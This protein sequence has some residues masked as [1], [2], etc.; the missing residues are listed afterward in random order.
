MIAKY[1]WVF[2]EKFSVN[3]IKLVTIIVL[4]RLITP[5]EFGVFAIAMYIITTCMV[6]VD[7]GMAGSLIKERNINN[8]DYSTVNYYNIFLSLFLIFLIYILSDVVS[9]YYQ[10]QDLALMLKFMSIFL[11]IR[12]FTIVH[13]VYLSKKMEFR[14]QTYV[15][16]FSAIVGGLGAVILAW[17]NYGVWSLIAQQMI[18]LLSIYFI[19]R[20]MNSKFSYGYSFSIKTL[21]KHFNF[22]IKLTFSTILESLNNNIIINYIGKIGGINLV[23]QYSQMTKVN[24]IYLGVISSAVDKAALPIFVRNLNN[25][26]NLL[27]L[28]KKT[29]GFLG[30]FVYLGISILIIN[31][32][33]VVNILLGNNWVE[34]SWILQILCLL[35]YMQIVDTIVRSYLKAKD[36]PNI[37]LFNS[38][39]KFLVFF[40]GM[41]LSYLFTNDVKFFVLMLVVWSL[42][43]TVISLIN[44]WFNVERR[45]FELVYSVFKPLLV[46][47][48]TILFFKNFYFYFESE[49]LLNDFFYFLLNCMVVST[50]YFLL[51]FVFRVK[52]FF[53]IL[54]IIKRRLL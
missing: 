22:G 24:D 49:S 42:M 27:E 51:L 9:K 43:Y 45:I 36:L 16:A 23:G 33:L 10:N 52:E 26:N 14:K 29:L 53:T 34:Y 35:G 40:V 3:L 2:A 46:S 11:L 37:I 12:S 7:S 8:T 25:E 38:L 6:V 41:L 18:E 47:F 13:I 39:I 28:T 21:K 54:D 15:Y 5:N 17:K 4:A 31:S 32:S 19:L 48:L 1:L 50:L 44:V 30:I 20:V